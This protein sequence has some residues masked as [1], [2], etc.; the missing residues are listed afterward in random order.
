MRLN[1]KVLPNSG[2][3][4]IRRSEDGI[5]RVYLKKPAENGKANDE[6]ISFLT[7]HFGAKV[8]IVKG[9]SSRKKI[10]EISNGD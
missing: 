1:V 7:K 8:K 9:F 3:R 10:V 6:L 2:R 5:Y 4:E